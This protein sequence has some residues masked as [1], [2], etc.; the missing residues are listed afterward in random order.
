MNENN[1]LES[2]CGYLNG[3]GAGTFMPEVWRE[4][5]FAIFL[6]NK[7]D[8]YKKYVNGDGIMSVEF[9]VAMRCP[10]NA[11]GDRIDVLKKFARL[12]SY[13]G[14][15]P[16]PVPNCEVLFTSGAEKSKVLKDGSEEYRAKCCFRYPKKWA[17]GTD[18]V[19][20]SVRRYYINVGE[21]SSPIWAPIGLGFLK[22][23][24]KKNPITVS[25]R[26]YHEEDTRSDNGGYSAEIRYEVELV[27]PSPAVDCLRKVADLELYGKDAEV[28]VM[29][30]DLLDE[31]HSSGAYK[32]WT[33][34]YSVI[35]DSLGD[36]TGEFVYSGRLLAN[37]EIN[38][39]IYVSSTGVFTE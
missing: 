18:A 37:G 39:G 22:F 21:D 35:P 36:K 32:A 20:R 25:R 27:T 7:A 14:V 13:V 30:V 8:W 31:V 17:D 38:V 3:A 16:F 24:E 6:G 4:G 29:T 19:K 26:Y 9:D 2:L 23:E 5:S 15:T 34:K 12:A 11:S 28:C 33:R 10:G 1:I